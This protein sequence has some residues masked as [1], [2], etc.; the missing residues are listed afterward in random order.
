MKAIKEIGLKKVFKYISNRIFIIIYNILMFNPLRISFLKLMGAKIGKNVILE[1]VKFFNLYR[2]G[3][4]GLNIEDNC[5]IGED[6]LLDMAG[7]IKL[8]KNVTFGERVTVL[9]H[10]NVGYKD[11]PLQ[12]YYPP[13]TKDVTFKEGCFI[14]TNS[15]ILAGVTIG[16]NSLAAAGSIIIKDVKP[17]TVVGGN[18]AKELKKLKRS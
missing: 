12:K 16:E 10:M 17:Y 7:N 6:C 4:K 13:I 2:T 1:N 11:H 9:T 8:E 15:T 3:M 14:G 5:F 18:P